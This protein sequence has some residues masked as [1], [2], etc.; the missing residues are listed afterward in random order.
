MLMGTRRP[1]THVVAGRLAGRHL[2]QPVPVG[3]GSVESSG[4]RPEIGGDLRRVLEGRRRRARAASRPGFRRSPRSRRRRRGRTPGP[5]RPGSTP[6]RWLDELDEAG[7]RR[8]GGE[9]RFLGE[10]RRHL[11]VRVEPRLDA[12]VGLEQAAAFAEHDARVRLVRADVALRTDGR[13]VGI[14]AP[15]RQTSAAV[16]WPA[17][18][19]DGKRRW[20]GRR[21]SPRPA[22]ATLRRPA[23]TREAARRSGP[24]G[25]LV[26]AC[27]P[28][29]TRRWPGHAVRRHRGRTPRRVAPRD[30]PPFAP[31]QRCLGDAAGRGRAPLD[32]GRVG[33]SAAS[34]AFV[35]GDLRSPRPC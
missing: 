31:N 21:P 25:T 26:R 18:S 8:D 7:Q 24:A 20:S 33:A 4:Q 27:R 17:S 29:R 34:V 5:W 10:E 28:A 14:A 2:G 16:E 11:E 22:P 30:R 6:W 32:G 12:S 35:G 15:G 9:C 23:R 1:A 3:D 13:P 19:P